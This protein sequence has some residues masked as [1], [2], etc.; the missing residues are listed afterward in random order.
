MTSNG[1]DEQLLIR[2][3]WD[4]GTGLT[5]IAGECT[6]LDTQQ[7]TNYYTTN[8]DKY[9]AEEERLVQRIFKQFTLPAMLGLP[10]HAASHTIDQS[11]EHIMNQ[12]ASKWQCFQHGSTAREK[13]TCAYELYQKQ[14]N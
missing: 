14:Q 3:L 10:N 1:I 9:T 11:Y 8:G 12:L 2:K 4:M 13:L 7:S 6:T 5:S